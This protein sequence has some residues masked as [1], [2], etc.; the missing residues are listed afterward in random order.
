MPN[1]VD[2]VNVVS[3]EV[4]ITPQQLK[5]EIPLTEQ[6]RTTVLAGRQAVRDILDRKDHR[7]FMVIGP[8]SI[9]VSK[10]ALISSTIQLSFEFNE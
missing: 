5:E 6:A 1:N 8:C 3:Q 9:R 4:L 7:L 10:L 2:N